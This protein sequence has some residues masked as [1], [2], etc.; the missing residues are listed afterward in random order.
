MKSD[1]CGIINHPDQGY[2]DSGIRGQAPRMCANGYRQGL[3]AQQDDGL[4]YLDDPG[5]AQVA[6]QARKLLLLT[7][8]ATGAAVSTGGLAS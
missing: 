8:A 6:D 1:E 4:P 2:P 3:E 7:D 5:P